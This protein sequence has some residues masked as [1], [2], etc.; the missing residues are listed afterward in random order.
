MKDI[1]LTM[2]DYCKDLVF[3]IVLIVFTIVFIVMTIV[4]IVRPIVFHSL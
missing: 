2:K 1:V 3:T 4:F